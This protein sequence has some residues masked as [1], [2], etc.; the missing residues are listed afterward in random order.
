MNINRGIGASIALRLARDGAKVVVN[1]VKDKKSADAVVAAITTSGGV[2][3]A[4]QG[5]ASSSTDIDRLFNETKKLY[6]RV[7]IVVA[8]AG[9]AGG[10][11]LAT[12]TNEDFDAIF[13]VNVKGVFYVLRAAANLLENNGISYYYTYDHQ[14]HTSHNHIRAINILSLFNFVCA[15]MN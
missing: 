10:K 14:Y 8:N 4:I 12:T 1:Y 9:V 2:A 3:S 11:T 6:G 5:D 15:G 13:N 7:D